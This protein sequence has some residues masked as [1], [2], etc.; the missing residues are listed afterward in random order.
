MASLALAAGLTQILEALR[1]PG[2]AMIISKRHVV[3]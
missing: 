3:E 1:F 2:P